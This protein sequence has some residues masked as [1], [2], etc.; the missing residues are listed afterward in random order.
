M[1]P[2]PPGDQGP[3]G[4]DAPG[5]GRGR[6]RR[7]PDG[8]DGTGG[9]GDPGESEAESRRRRLRAQPTAYDNELHYGETNRR[10]AREF[11]GRNENAVADRPGRR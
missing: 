3:P 5:G 10:R 2:R 4:D 7:R 8:P 1:S 11:L 6:R 9:P